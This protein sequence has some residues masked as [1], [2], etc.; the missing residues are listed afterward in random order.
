MATKNSRE[1]EHWEPC[2]PGELSRMVERSRSAQRKRSL[3]RRGGV[4]TALLLLAVSIWQFSADSGGGNVTDFGGITCSEVQAAIPEL[5]SDDLDEEKAQQMKDHLAY[6]G[7]CRSKAEQMG[8]VAM[9][10]HHHDT[11][12]DATCVHCQSQ[13]E[14][15]AR[16]L[17]QP[18]DV[19]GLMAMSL[20]PT[21]ETLGR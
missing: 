18:V 12:D 11:C 1:N 17:V 7:K 4:T 19:P 2:P 8:W 20:D 6:C 9:H 10:R 15:I 16:G 14:L 3:V 13:A 5:L 21:P